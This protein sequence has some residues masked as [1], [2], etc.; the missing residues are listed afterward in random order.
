MTSLWRLDLYNSHSDCQHLQQRMQGKADKHV[1][2]RVS[3]CKH[4][5]TLIVLTTCRLLLKR[6]NIFKYLFSDPV[7]LKFLYYCIHSRIEDSSWCRQDGI[8]DGDV[9]GLIG[10]FIG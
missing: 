8:N 1:C 5:A 3:V 6:D 9:R 4:S 10:L 2:V 7:W